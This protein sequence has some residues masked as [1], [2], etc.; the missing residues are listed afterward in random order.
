MKLCN[1]FERNLAIRG[2]VIEISAF[3]VLMTFNTALRVELGSGIIFTNFDLRQ[4]I[5]AWIIA[6]FGA[7]TLCHA[8]ILTF[9]LLT[10]DLALLDLAL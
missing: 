6:Y 2:G 9:G 10:L 3:G 1:K 4:L 5:R 8:V 7:D